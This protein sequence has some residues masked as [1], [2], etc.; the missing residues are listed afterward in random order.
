MSVCLRTKWLWVRALLLLQEYFN[1]VRLY[2][3]TYFILITSVLIMR[4]AINEIFFLNILKKNRIMKEIADYCYRE[5]NCKQNLIH[6]QPRMMSC[7]NNMKTLTWHNSEKKCHLKMK[8]RTDHYFY[9]IFYRKINW[10]LGRA[11]I[12][13]SEHY[14][15]VIW[16]VLKTWTMMFSYIIFLF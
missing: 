6:F 5:T 7:K 13:K 2:L 4:H 8:F 3:Q 10:N 14:S 1:N 16:K 15:L 9:K 12:M 11:L